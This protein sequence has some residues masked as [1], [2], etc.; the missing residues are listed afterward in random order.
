VN[1]LLTSTLAG[2]TIPNDY[3]ATNQ[4]R[5]NLEQAAKLDPLEDAKSAQRSQL[6]KERNLNVL[7]VA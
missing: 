2:K 6:T 5:L 7:P 4:W 1:T 3:A